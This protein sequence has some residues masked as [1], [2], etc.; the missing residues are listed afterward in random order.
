MKSKRAF[1]FILLSLVLIF[2]HWSYVRSAVLYPTAIQAP[3]LKWQQGGCYSS[4]CET[5]WYSSPAVADIDGDGTPEVINSAYSILSL[6]GAT[7]TQEWIIYSGFDRT[8][9]HDPGDSVGRTWPGIVIADINGDGELEIATAHSGGYV[10]VY[11]S[12]G[13]FESGWPKRPVTS[14]LRGLSVYDLDADS[15]LEVIVTAAVGS[16]INTGVYEHTGALRAGWPQLGHQPGELLAEWVLPTSEY[17]LS[18][19]YTKIVTTQPE[20]IR[21]VFLGSFSPQKHP[22]SHPYLRKL[23]SNQ[24]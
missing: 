18:T 22:P 10:S 14:E 15:T 19:Y 6:D 21:G 9:V 4:W 7:G 12:D 16:K 11:N 3:V 1:L 2:S 24:K 5:G 20:G 8:K 17:C 13:Y 23:S